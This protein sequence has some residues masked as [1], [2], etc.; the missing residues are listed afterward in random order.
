MIKD[1]RLSKRTLRIVVISLFGAILSI[2]FMVFN[3]ISVQNYL[4]PFKTEEE[5]QVKPIY[6]GAMK[7]I[8]EFKLTDVS[9]DTKD[10]NVRFWLELKKDTTSDSFTELQLQAINQA[11]EQLTE[12]LNGSDF[13]DSLYTGYILNIQ[14]G[15]SDIQV[16][17]KVGYQ[18]N[19]YEF[20]SLINCTANAVTDFHMMKNVC[21]IY[22]D[23]SFQREF[24]YENVRN[25]SDFSNLEEISFDSSSNNERVTEFAKLMHTVLPKCKVYINEE[26]VLITD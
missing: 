8:S 17:C 1:Q 5:K 3:Y 23:D 15:N 9:F 25:F 11:V 6:Q 7:G 18:K 19:R 4:S 26:E 10:H 2:C 13:I 20:I 21:S 24:V 14:I 22:N 12:Y 16:I